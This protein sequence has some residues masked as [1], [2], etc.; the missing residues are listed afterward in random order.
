MA[1]QM[2]CPDVH[3][4][5]ANTVREKRKEILSLPNKENVITMCA[6]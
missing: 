2:V 4:E 3:V 6:L 5:S 1:M